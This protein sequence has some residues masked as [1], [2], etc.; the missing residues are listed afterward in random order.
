MMTAFERV[1]A[2][3][4]GARVRG[5]RVG[6]IT[7]GVPSV[8][9]IHG[10][11]GS[12]DDW[13]DVGPLVN[14]GTGV[15]VLAV[16]YRGHGDSDRFGPYQLANYT[17]DIVDVIQR[18]GIGPV[19]LVGSSFGGSVALN[20]ARLSEPG[21]VL[22]ASAFASAVSFGTAAGVDEVV[23]RLGGLGVEGF[24]RAVMPR[25]TFAPSANHEAVDRAI[26]M[27]SRNDPATVEAILRGVFGAGEVVADVDY[28]CRTVAVTGS[29]DRTCPS[30]DGASLARRIG[31]PHIVLDGVGHMPM[32]EDPDGTAR[33]II[34]MI[35]RGDAT[36][37][38]Q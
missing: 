22:S 37:E 8:V 30:A 29:L 15:P 17:D 26:E 28:G 6:A 16:S 32:V 25:W 5:W 36:I 18:E 13:T 27:A 21:R 24:F 1:A 34:D 19:H 4:A 2:G 35:S 20:I 11:N 38:T 7:P 31:G 12:A 14:T 23:A 3:A 33:I 10:I 9:L